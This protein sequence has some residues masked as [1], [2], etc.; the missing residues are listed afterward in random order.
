MEWINLTRQLCDT[1]TQKGDTLRVAVVDCSKFHFPVI[2]DVSFF[3]AQLELS[4]YTILKPTIPSV[5]GRNLEAPG[6]TSQ[7]ITI[8]G[9]WR[10][11]LVSELSRLETLHSNIGIQIFQNNKDS[12]GQMNRILIPNGR[13][14]FQKELASFVDTLD[15]KPRIQFYETNVPGFASNPLS[16]RYFLADFPV[17]SRVRLQKALK[18]VDLSNT[19]PE[20]VFWSWLEPRRQPTSITNHFASKW[21]E[22]PGAED[23]EKPNNK[24]VNLFLTSSTDEFVALGDEWKEDSWEDQYEAFEK[25]IRKLKEQGEGNFVLRIHPNLANKSLRF[26]REELSRITWLKQTHPDLKILGPL[27][28][29]NT[30]SLIDDS[31][32]VFVSLS[33]AGLE[34]SGMG[35]PVW[36]TMANNYDKFADVRPLMNPEQVEKDSL[37]VWKVDKS[38]AQKYVTAALLFGEKYTKSSPPSTRV[39]PSHKLAAI[40]FRDLSFRILLFCYRYLQQRRAQR[41]LRSLQ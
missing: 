16:P 24:D 35:L 18:D 31:K 13:F 41:M 8:R 27:S 39:R 9:D 30:Y 37:T 36:N 2:Q 34:A 20:E 14:T 25:V 28:P 4:P 38:K 15:L 40:G 19:R 21:S 1:L 7:A 11:H 26:V 6:I 22:S 12:F 23:R 33:M 5:R 17:H 10:G 29:K 32:R 3:K